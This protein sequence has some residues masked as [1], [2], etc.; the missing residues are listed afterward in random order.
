MISEHL[1]HLVDVMLY[2]FTHELISIQVCICTSERDL[3]VSEHSICNEYT[4]VLETVR[5]LK[6]IRLGSE[7]DV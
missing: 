5:T 2:V 4:E 7:R 6:K 3:C 1:R